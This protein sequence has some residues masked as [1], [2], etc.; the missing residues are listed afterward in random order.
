MVDTLREWL[1]TTKG[2][3]EVRSGIHL[4]TVFSQLI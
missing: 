1:S 4:P 3:P 2:A